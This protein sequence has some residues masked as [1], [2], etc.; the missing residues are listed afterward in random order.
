M[1]RFILR[2]FAAIGMV[3]T[4]LFAAGIFLWFLLAPSRPA[5]PATTLLTLDLTVAPIDGPPAAG[6]ATL[7]LEEKTSHLR[8]IL[9]GLERA[10]LDP[11]VK[12]M[13]VRVGDGGF[14]LA[15]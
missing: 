15:E 12:G 11:R 10:A 4:A 8:D 7:L 1:R 3:V 13:L 5:V 14:G 6:L 9:D 2:V